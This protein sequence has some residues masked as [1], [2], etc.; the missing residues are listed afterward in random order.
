MNSLSLIINLVI[1]AIYMFRG[2]ILFLFGSFFFFCSVQAQYGS[3]GLTDARQLALGN[4]YASNSRELYAAGKNPSLLAY[5]VHDRKIDFLFPNLSAR[6]YNIAKVSNFLNDFF[7]QKP[8]DILIGLDGSV[9]KRAFEKGGSLYLG[10]QIGFL[11]A[12]YTPN[13]KIGS[14]SFAVKDY[15][16]GFLKLPTAITEYHQGEYDFQGIY[17]NEFAF[18]S[19]WTRSYELTYARMFK[20]NPSTGIIAIYAGLGLKYISGYIYSDIQFSGGLGYEDEFGILRGS[21]TALSL[22]ASSD[23][24]KI[25]NAFEGKDVV[26]NVPFMEPVG[27]GIG[28]DVGLT[29]LLDPGV[30]VG[31]S[32]TDVGFINWDGKTKRTQVSGEFFIDSTLTIDDID[33]IAD[34][35]VIEKE[36]DDSFQSSPPAALHLGFNFMIDRFVKNFPGK[37][38]LAV[39]IHKGLNDIVDN[40]DQP[41]IAVGLDWQA[42][43]YW[44][45]VLTGIYGNQSGEL[46]WSA[47][48]GYDVKFMELYFA[49]PDIVP[50]LEGSPLETLSLSICWHF[51]KTERKKKKA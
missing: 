18:K 7:S 15:L 35:I 40:P 46:A 6:A 37:M 44:P 49:L 32:L 21:Y 33:S 9:I 30:K 51:V 42:G 12:S 45:I 4:T 14:F 13:E 17:F 50:L 10:L 36:S 24:I 23:D 20:M 39:E 31:I 8:L 25:E 29:L 48:L 34:K 16:T 22:A 38:N 19:S 2:I 47:G 26:N 11:A 43:Q 1:I 28:F 27:K 5:R 3:F 41:R